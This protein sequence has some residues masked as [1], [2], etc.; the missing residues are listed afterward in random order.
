M[1]KTSIEWTAFSA[2]PIKY[3][4]LSDGKTVW[5]CV[6]TSPGCANCYSETIALRFNRGKLFNAR[7]MEEV[8]PFLCDAESRKMRTAKTISGERVSGSRCF[9][10]DMTDIFGEWI[11]DDLLNQLFSNVLE[12]RTDVTWQILTKRAERMSKYLQ[13]R[14]GDGRIPS[15]NIHVGVSCENQ[16]TANERIL[17][18]LRCQAAV[19]F[20]SHEP[21]LDYADP[22]PGIDWWIIGCES[23]GRKVGRLGKFRDDLDWQEAAARV[24]HQCRVHGVSPFVKQCPVGTRVSHDPNEWIEEC[25]VREFPELESAKAE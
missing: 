4:Q 6:K 1:N 23:S 7:N 20:V 24:V 16:Q 18:L 2:N 25:R 17:H 22:V 10:G 5:A 11:S 14:W 13:W 9:I 3:R 15:R 12:I 21:M 19:R 8:E